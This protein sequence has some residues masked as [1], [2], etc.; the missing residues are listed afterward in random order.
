MTIDY[1]GLARADLNLLV[2]LDALLTKRNVTRAAKQVGVGQSAMSASLA[3]LRKMTGDELLTRAPDGMRLTPRAM[4]LVEPVRTAL[5]QFQ[6]IVERED[7]FE[8]ATVQRTFTV[9]MPG[10][11]EAFIGPRLLAKLRAEAPGVR[12]CFESLDYGDVLEALDADRL[13]IAIGLITEGQTHHK[14]RPLYRY[15]YL[16]LFNSELVKV[17]TPISLEDYLSYP[18]IMTS[19]TRSARG[20]VDDALEAIGKERTLAATTPRFMTVP[21]LVQ[22]SPVITTMVDELAIR[23]AKLLGLTTSPVP[24]EVPDFTISMVWHASY[25]QDPAHRWMRDCLASIARDAAAEQAQAAG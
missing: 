24:V 9:A 14:A 18:H 5:R 13:D 21:F 2:A 1:R 15:G 20:V 11:M 4:A 12:L 22:S 25:D 23:F 7:S 16:C 10:S 6:C 8:P 19:L 3:R 17:D